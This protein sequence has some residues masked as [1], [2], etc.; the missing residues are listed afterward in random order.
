MP[1]RYWYHCTQCT[2]RA[3]RYRNVRR[4]PDCGGQLVRETEEVI[5][6]PRHRG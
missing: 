6:N 5:S 3:F 2:Y 1:Q 4:C